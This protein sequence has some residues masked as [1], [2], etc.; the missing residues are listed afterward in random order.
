M[1]ACVRAS[2]SRPSP[3]PHLHAACRSA[4]NVAALPYTAQILGCHLLPDAAKGLSQITGPLDCAGAGSPC[5][6]AAKLRVAV[7]L[8]LCTEAQAMLASSTDTI[9]VPTL[10]RLLQMAASA[11]LSALNSITVTGADMRMRE[12][13]CMGP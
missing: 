5:E 12:G 1:S 4:N 3:L 10:E 8:P 7:D 6:L 11:K 13:A 2:V 9:M